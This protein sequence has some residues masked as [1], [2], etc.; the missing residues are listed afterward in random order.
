MLIIREIASRQN[1]VFRR[2]AAIAAESGAA[3]RESVLLEGFR[4]CRDALQSGIQPRCLV[5]S[6]RLDP[7]RRDEI[8]SLA[9]P[10]TEIVLLSDAL[11]RTL[12]DT[13]N[14]QG[15]ALVFTR[16][17]AARLEESVCAGSRY[18]VLENVQDPG[19]VG[20]MIRTADAM[21]FD[22]V[23]ILPGTA[24][25]YRAKAIRSAMG[26]TFHLPVL[27]AASVR[28]AADWL[29]QAGC[30]LYAAHLH[31]GEL[32]AH[33]LAAPGALLVGNEG[34]GLTDEAV[35][36][37]DR[38]VR[39]PMPGRAESLNAA[40]AA[41]VLCY[42][43]RIGQNGPESEGIPCKPSSSAADVSPDTSRRG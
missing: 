13:V 38:L 42:S 18:L 33:G 2:L 29:R 43:M 22:G 23:V 26:S 36:L 25:P 27:R 7:A 15:A 41:A 32:T 12:G 5:F 11:F 9:S 21:G 16:P 28:E 31:G 6:D 14:P 35:A 24:D 17:S 34:A 30:I 40:C 20:T 39:I 8:A 3:A 37:A 1:P 10:G 4:L 19:N